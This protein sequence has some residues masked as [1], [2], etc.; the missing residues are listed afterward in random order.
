VLEC[1]AEQMSSQP[2]IAG[3]ELSL[4]QSAA[5]IKHSSLYIGVDTGPMHMAAIAGI[6]VVALFW[7]NGPR[8]C[9]T[10]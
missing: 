6:P 5:L 9:R 2:L 4:I 1:I 8:T 10:L 3:G 7:S